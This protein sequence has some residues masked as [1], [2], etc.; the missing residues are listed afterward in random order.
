EPVGTPERHGRFGPVLGQGG[1][2]LALAT[3]EDYAKDSGTAAHGRN[4][5]GIPVERA[6]WT[7]V[8]HLG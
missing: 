2:T 5:T 7:A 6:I 1:K 4:V 8:H 3:G